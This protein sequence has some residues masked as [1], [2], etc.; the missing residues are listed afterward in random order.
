MI[1]FHAD[2]YGLFPAQSQ[3]ILDCIQNGCLNGISVMPNSPHLSE[4]MEMLR[5]YQKGLSIAVHL[6]FMEG[7]SVCAPEQVNLLT[8]SHGIFNVS[9]EKFLLISCL[10]NKREYQ[11]QLCREIS[12]QIHAL[13]PYLEPDRALRID[14]HV[15]Y[16]MVPMIFDSLIQV[17]EEE[18]L[19]V[20]YIRIPREQ[21]SIYWRIKGMAMRIKLI[22]WLKVLILN[23][24]AHRNRKKYGETLSKTEDKLFLGVALSGN[25]S[26]AN[27]SAILP[28]AVKEADKRGQAMEILAHP[29]GVYAPSDVAQLTNPSDIAFMTSNM[30]KKEKEMFC[31]LP[32]Q[33]KPQNRESVRNKK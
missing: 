30:R 29:G 12:A 26:Y 23:V 24:L 14:G 19:N 9:F 3:E 16:H 5:P 2:D 20:E 33:M 7:H 27:V 4:C 13:I 1:E 32:G 10:P 21:C 18:K 31:T 15:H 25:M 22:N 8:D 11:R 28:E 6:N 17:I